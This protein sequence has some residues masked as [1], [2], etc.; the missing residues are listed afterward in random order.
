MPHDI[1]LASRQAEAG[2]AVLALQ[3][4][5][6]HHKT[7]P[8]RLFYDHEGCRLFYRITE[9]PEYYLTRTELALLPDVALELPKLIVTPAALVEYGASDET[10]ASLLLARTDAAGRPIFPVYVP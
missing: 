5:L 6:K 3:G 8:A 2:T 4:L 9:L 7:L 1:I 10:K